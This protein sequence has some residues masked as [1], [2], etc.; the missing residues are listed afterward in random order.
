MNKENRVCQNCH[1]DFTIEPEDFEFYERIK[2]PAPTFCPDCREQRRI[3]FRNERALYRRN[4]ALCQTSIVAR[5]SPDK[6]YPVYCNK[7]W[8]SDGWDAMT[9]GQDYDFSK[10]FFEQF[11]ELLFK[12]PHIALGASN[13][14]NSDWVN[15]E[16]DDKNC[17][18]NVGG[19]I[20]EDSGYNTYELYSKDCFD[21]FWCFKSELCYQCV[22][23]ERCFQTIYS[24]ECFDCR[25]VAFSEDCRNCDNCFGC[26]GLRNKQ[27]HLWNKDVGKEEYEKFIAANPLTKSNVI[28][29]FQKQAEKIWRTMPKRYS[30]IIKSVNSD[31]HFVTESK[32]THNAWNV[33]KNE[34]SKHMFITA[35]IKDCHDFSAAGWSEMSYEISSSVGVY[36][37]KSIVFSFG[38]TGERQSSNIEYCY[39]VSTSN[40]C[41]GCA[42][43]KNKQYCIL[44][45][46]YTK[47]EYEKILPQIIKHMD[48]MPYQ[49]KNNRTYKYGEFFP[50]EISPY[51]Y[52]ETAAVD[53]FPLTKEQ[54]SAQGLP[55][56]DFESET[57]PA[58]GYEIPEDSRDAKDEILEKILKCEISGKSYRLIPMELNFYRKMGL[59]LPRRAPL[60]R[61]KERIAKLLP[62]KISER[63][64]ECAGKNISKNDYKNT[65]EHFHGAAACPNSIKTPYSPDR[66][67]TIY[68]EVCYQSEII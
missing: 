12:T 1:R 16:T 10:P 36:N 49:G 17:Y 57:A 5:V 38:K 63:Q 42:N 19:H 59:P 46:Q 13:N 60:Q 39:M 62:R 51:G 61:H 52:N 33:E 64:C 45:K 48:D 14:I 24:R 4:C 35:G 68:C 30:F 31:G 22:N 37:A 47:E 21:N 11:R 28:A 50:I 26:A 40:N 23:I 20:N 41:F 67:E 3:A 27:Y 54:A 53:Y 58:S 2:V 15:Q 18:L 32:N 25:S 65:A 29:D 55:W 7:C 6:E 8:W 44:N 56:C 34:D 9:Y 43:I 66:P